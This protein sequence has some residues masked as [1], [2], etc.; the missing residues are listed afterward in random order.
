MK[1]HN[2]KIAPTYFQD[3]VSGKKK[4]EVRENDRG[5]LLGDI[6]RL[7][8]YDLENKRYTGQEVIVEIIYLL[9]NFYGLKENY[10]VLGISDWKV[11]DLG[12]SQFFRRN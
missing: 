5:F 1:V 7:K 12:N 11:L 4:F 3:V 8:E 9:E 10:V 6:L 2:L